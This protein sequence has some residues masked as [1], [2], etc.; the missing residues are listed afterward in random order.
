ML[1]DKVLDN[2]KKNKDFKSKGIFTGI[3]YPFPRLNEFLTSIDRGQAISVLGGSGVGKSKFTR[4]TFLYNTYKFYKET[5][6]KCRIIYF[7]LEDGKEETMNFV[8]C[9][10]LKEVCGIV[11]SHK[12]LLSRG[13]E[14]PDFVLEKLEEAKEYFAEFETIVS[15][16]DGE[17]EPTKM[18]EICKDIALKIGTVSS[19]IETI[20]GKEI[21]QWRY[22]SDTHV[23]A[24]FDNMSNISEEDDIVGEQAAILKFV[25]EYMRL[26][27]CNFFKW[28]CILV[29]QLDF[30]S[31]RPSFSKTG[32][33]NHAKLEPT[34]A[35][36]GD[37]KRAARS[38]HL[39]FSLF[40]PHRFD[41]IS[42]PQPKKDDPDNCYRIDI[43]A[44]KFRSL[45]VIKS[46]HTETGMRVGLL[47]DG[48]TEEFTELPLPKTPELDNIYKNIGGYK[49]LPQQALELKEKTTVMDEDSSEEMPF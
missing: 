23:V 26:K 39:I 20:E 22:E 6:Y 49:K 9:H 4:F 11:L 43:L 40:S 47:F 25:K 35:S 44:N 29:M 21:K 16:I 27:L 28:S 48:I 15:F 30:E 32:E 3:P 37:S 42:Y 18:Y 24:I 7:C 33:A 45:R 1:Y 41:L 17:D 34:L 36:I 14:L 2:I 31:E 8:L 13:R 19:Y 46:N 12:E 5:G 38:M 10:Y